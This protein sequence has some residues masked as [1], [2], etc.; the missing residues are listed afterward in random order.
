MRNRLI[1]KN[2]QPVNYT[3]L[4]KIDSDMSLTN[5]KQNN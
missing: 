4:T 1:A 3:K 2:C 5:N